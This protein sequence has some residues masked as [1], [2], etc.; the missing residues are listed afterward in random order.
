MFTKIKFW[1]IVSLLKHDGW[2]VGT[3]THAKMIMHG[4]CGDKPT[5]STWL[6]CWLLCQVW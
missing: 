6:K 4:E 5:L 1:L 3:R 2:C